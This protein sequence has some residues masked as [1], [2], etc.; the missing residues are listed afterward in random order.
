MDNAI[1]FRIADIADIEEMMRIRI[2]V[3]ENT[4]PVGIINNKDVEEAIT[5][6]G[7]GWVAEANGQ[8]LGF[9][10]GTAEKSHVWDL[11]VDPSHEGKGVARGLQ[12]KMLAWF[13]EIGCFTI[14]LST[15]PGT[16]AERFYLKS[17]WS[18]M[19][20][21]SKGEVLMEYQLTNGN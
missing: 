13:A 21:T 1:T 19:G 9:A 12:T 15:D 11:F 10:I 4:M 20:K 3:K 17:G 14:N 8:V 18:P 2:A 16:R 5:K 6:T 7:R